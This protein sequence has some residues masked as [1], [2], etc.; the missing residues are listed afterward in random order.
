M[1][2]QK[3]I[4]KVFLQATEEERKGLKDQ[5]TKH[6]GTDFD[7]FILLALATVIATFGLITNN[8]AVVIG[9]MILSPLMMK[10]LTVSFAV[11]KDDYDLFFKALEVIIKGV[12]IAIIV[13]MVFGLF[14]PYQ[15]ANNEILSRTSPTLFDLGIA[16]AAGAAAAY[17]T[18]RKEM[19]S[20]MAGVAISVAILPPL[21]VIG[22]GLSLHRPEIAF[23][24]FLLFLTNIVA[25]N[26]AAIVVFL[27][28]G[29]EPF[30]FKYNIAFMRQLKISG[31]LVLLISLPLAWIMYSTIEESKVRSTITD[32]LTETIELYPG[33]GVID[34]QVFFRSGYV[35]VQAT[36]K[37]T[38]KFSN[39]EITVIRDILSRSVGRKIEFKVDVV[40]IDMI[41]AYLP[42]EDKQRKFLGIIPY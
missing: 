9:A 26:F 35:E 17:S 2:V 40:N 10:I 23:G 5:L 38:K 25:I 22:I 18:V 39:D 14:S 20:S 21:A 37:S 33:T 28:M 15:Q 16:L 24:S 13:S 29:I 11:I 41:T 34:S 32:K 12:G 3:I 1:L 42:E 27:I 19:S 36:V 30:S 6:S 4:K 31:I 7:Y 8:T